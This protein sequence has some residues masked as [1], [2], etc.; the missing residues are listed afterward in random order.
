ML[1]G[2]II[3]PLK[4]FMSSHR[5][6]T[7]FKLLTAAEGFAQTWTEADLPPWV[8]IVVRSGETLGPG[9]DSSAAAPRSGWRSAMT[10]AAEPVERHGRPRPG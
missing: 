1:L 8:A 7:S 5:S 6:M 4:L 9:H 10:G 3:K 2:A